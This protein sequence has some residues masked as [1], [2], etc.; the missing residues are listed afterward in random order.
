[1]SEGVEP[2]AEHDHFLPDEAVANALQTMRQIVRRSPDDD[3]VNPITLLERMSGSTGPRY[4]PH[5]YGY[6]NYARSALHRRLVFGDA[7]KGTAGIGSVLGGTGIA[8]SARCMPTPQLAAHLRWLMQPDTQSSFIPRYHGQPSHRA[9]WEN[10]DLNA[11]FGQ[12]YRRTR[13]T[14]EAAWIRPRFEGFIRV[15]SESA[16]QIRQAVHGDLTAAELRLAPDGA[17]P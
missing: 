2:T 17:A 10:P 6:V 8:V 3:D 1:M 14:I 15:Q 7:P 13:A 4:C 11:E 16:E 9:A 5:V 12:F